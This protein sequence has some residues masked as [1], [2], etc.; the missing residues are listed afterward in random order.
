MLERVEGLA[1][2]DALSYSL[3]LAVHEAC[4]NIVEHA[5]A[6]Q[7]GKFW[8]TFS[9]STEPA[10]LITELNDL[11][12]SFNP[13]EIPLPDLDTGQ[14]HGYGLF[15]VHQIMD[16]VIYQPQQPGNYWRL[17]KYF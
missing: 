4:S 6:S 14:E 11:G 12:S 8:V 5:Y 17:V 15:L 1:D 2:R 7:D 10:C 9:V 13:S 16:E 3:Q